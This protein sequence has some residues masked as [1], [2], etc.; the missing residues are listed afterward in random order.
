MT[1]V[2]V[3]VVGDI[4]MA[5]LNWLVGGR[6]LH[7]ATAGQGIGRQFPTVVAPD[8]LVKANAPKS[9]CQLLC[10]AEWMIY[11]QNWRLH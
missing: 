11:T 4:Y 7:Q 2:G 6:F 1:S 3:D 8:G 5:L 10:A 9:F